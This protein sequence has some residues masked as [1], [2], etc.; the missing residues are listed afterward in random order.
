MRR[1]LLVLSAVLLSAL[2][3]A[4]PASHLPHTTHIRQGPCEEQF[5]A[6]PIPMAQA[7]QFAPPGFP[8]LPFDAAGTLPPNPL[9]A[10]VVTVG[11]RCAHTTGDGGLALGEVRTVGRALVVDAPEHLRAPH[12]DNYVIVFGGWTSSPALAQVY[13]N[14][15]LPNVE[16]GSVSFN[17]T[18]VNGNLRIADVAGESAAGRLQVLTI[19]AGQEE[20]Q[21]ADTFRLFGFD[22]G[23]VAGYVDWSW[24]A[25]ARTIESGVALQ[26]I[27]GTGGAPEATVGVAFHY[28]GAYEYRIAYTPLH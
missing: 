21:Q 25:G 14:W 22:H 23:R 8:P 28:F 2:L 12:V 6:Y 3:P 26:T 13:T 20:A 24:P 10:T 1:A 9:L 15:H 4:V 19:A 11:Y 16:V 7:E 5:V 18:A 17:M 27:T